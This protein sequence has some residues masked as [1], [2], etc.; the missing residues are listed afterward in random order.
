[1]ER[2]NRRNGNFF[3]NRL[4]KWSVITDGTE[5]FPKTVGKVRE[6][7]QTEGQIPNEPSEK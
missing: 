1:M 6:K 2:Y 7:S 4:R 3:A 5:N